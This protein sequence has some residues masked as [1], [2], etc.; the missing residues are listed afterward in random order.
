MSGIIL[1]IVPLHMVGWEI[2]RNDLFPIFLLSFLHSNSALDIICLALEVNAL[3]IIHGLK[4]FFPM[5]S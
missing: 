3:S 1:G 5:L 2:D 4:G